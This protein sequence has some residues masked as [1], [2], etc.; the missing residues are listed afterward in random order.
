M[1]Y[2]KR[3]ILGGII[4]SERKLDVVT[5]QDLTSKEI[6][7]LESEEGMT[8]VSA[9]FAMYRYRNIG[10]NLHLAFIL[11]CTLIAGILYVAGVRPF[12][13][14]AVAALALAVPYLVRKIYEGSEYD[15]Y[16]EK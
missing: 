16:K 3:H 7:R 11:L 10:V 9:I 5:W 8:T 2:K 1:S 12:F 14:L 13:C 6:K 15:I 4:N